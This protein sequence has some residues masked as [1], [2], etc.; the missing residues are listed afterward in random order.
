MPDS[1][2]SRSAIRAAYLYLQSAPAQKVW[3]PSPFQHC[4][5][6]LGPRSRCH[7]DLRKVIKLVGHS[8]PRQRTGELQGLN[9]LSQ[10]WS[11]AIGFAPESVGDGDEM[12]KDTVNRGQEEQLSHEYVKDFCWS[13]TEHVAVAECAVFNECGCG[14][15]VQAFGMFGPL[16][17]QFLPQ[18]SRA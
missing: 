13:N 5:D 15:D 8:R 2:T 18:A 9:Q 16:M 6:D 4:Q 1:F 12:A 7:W 11:I 14:S 17:D 3:R 10:T